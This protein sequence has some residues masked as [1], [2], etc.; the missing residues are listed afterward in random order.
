MEWLH[1]NG[2]REH[3]LKARLQVVH[4]AMLARNAVQAA[5]SGSAK[6]AN[7]A[8]K[9]ADSAS[10][11]ANSTGKCAATA[12]NTDAVSSGANPPRPEQNEEAKPTGG[13]SRMPAAAAEANV[14]NEAPR[15]DIDVENDAENMDGNANLGGTAV[16]T[17][18]AV[19]VEPEP[20]AQAACPDSAE[21]P[22]LEPVEAMCP[23]VAEGACPE[24]AE[25]TCPDVGKAS[26]PEPAEVTCPKG[27]EAACS[28]PAKAT[29]QELAGVA[30]PGPV[31]ISSEAVHAPVGSPQKLGELLL[32]LEQSLT[33]LSLIHI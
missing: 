23:K 3:A 4:V 20:R 7:S 29:C 17:K 22:C 19:A 33:S 2:E 15:I 10:K 26:C 32:S 6:R 5:V 11:C 24:P 21:A 25:A 18:V 9:R 13:D 16:E 28:E 8:A 12:V 30:C 27:P 31:A 1:S 14:D